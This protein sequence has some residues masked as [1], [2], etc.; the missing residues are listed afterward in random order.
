MTKSS[1]PLILPHI[2]VKNCF[3][4][5]QEINTQNYNSLAIVQQAKTSEKPYW[6]K[7]IFITNYIK[8]FHYYIYSTHVNLRS[9]VSYTKT[10]KTLKDNKIVTNT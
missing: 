5:V 2:Y 1:L 6:S 7:K 9:N 8:I 4:N 10:S 3:I